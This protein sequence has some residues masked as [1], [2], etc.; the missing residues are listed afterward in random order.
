MLG[1]AFPFRARSRDRIVFGSKGY[2]NESH[3]FEFGTIRKT[4]DTAKAV[5]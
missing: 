5:R 2:S 3:D 4:Y 1:S